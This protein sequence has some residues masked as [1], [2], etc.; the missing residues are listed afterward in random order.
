MTTT[1]YARKLWEMGY[2]ARAHPWDDRVHV[3]HVGYDYWVEP[4]P[5]RRSLTIRRNL[6]RARTRDEID[7]AIA[8][9][10]A[11]EKEC[12][13]A[14]IPIVNG[15][16]KAIITVTIPAADEFP[17][18]FE[19]AFDTM[20]R[21][22]D[23]FVMRMR[24]TLPRPPEVPLPLTRL[25][26]AEAYRDYLCSLGYDATVDED[27]DVEFTADG[28]RY[29]LSPDYESDTSAHLFPN[30]C[31]VATVTDPADRQRAEAAIQMA[32]ESCPGAHLWIGN[33]GEVYA[34]VRLHLSDPLTISDCFA[35]RF[36]A[37]TS[38][39]DRFAAEWTAAQ[40]ATA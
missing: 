28:R 11:A 27:E 29:T 25:T 10:R 31:V 19:R 13:P 37:L 20:L 38:A 34:A 18:T 26:R 33:D 2:I 17:R 30:G 12:P 6:W 8:A 39:I 36:A 9:A 32:T 1:D 24:R 35:D 7:C 14:R 23:E 21:A 16:A 40:T 15:H 5:D 4:G 22:I 3:R